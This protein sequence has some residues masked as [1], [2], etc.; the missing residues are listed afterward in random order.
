MIHSAL[1]HDAADRGDGSLKSHGQSQIQ[2]LEHMPFGWSAL[3]AVRFQFREFPDDTP[4][5]QP[6]RYRL[7][8]NRGD[9]RP[10]NA[11]VKYRDK[12]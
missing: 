7:G 2:Q 1:Q 12:Q 3:L 4:D 5:A 8:C 9:G 6:P 11:P 10:H